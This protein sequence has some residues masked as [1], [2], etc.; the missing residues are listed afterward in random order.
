M[1]NQPDNR[2]GKPQGGQSATKPGQQKP[3]TERQ[4]DRA[5][6][7]TTPGQQKR[8]QDDATTQPDDDDG[9]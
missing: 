2:G 6:Q 5:P 4:D 9:A 7:R 1:P 3:D 8:P